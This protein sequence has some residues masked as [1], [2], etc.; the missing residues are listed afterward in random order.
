MAGSF[1]DYLEDR[2]LDHIFGATASTAP[3]TLYCGLS[4]TTITDAGG[5]ITEP[6]GNNYSR[7]AIT[8]NSTNFPASSGGAK[9]NGTA[10]TFPTASGSWGT[11]T[12]AFLSDASSGGNIYVWADLTVSKSITSGDTFSFPVGDF[13]ITL[14]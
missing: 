7:V 10:I 13:D 6:S 5:N 12:H 14:A 9:A 1:A 2:V 11:C 4:T 8:N 3:V